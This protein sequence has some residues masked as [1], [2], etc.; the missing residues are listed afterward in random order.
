MLW[1]MEEAELNPVF[2]TGPTRTSLALDPNCIGFVQVG[3]Q[4]RNGEDA[5]FEFGDTIAA[6]GRLNFKT[7]SYRASPQLDTG[8]SVK[9]PEWTPSAIGWTLAEVIG[10][11]R[12]IEPNSSDF[13]LRIARA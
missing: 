2:D 5:P 8:V 7:S 6:H 13:V 9:M 11:A 3:L 12:S 1:A 4:R 10:V